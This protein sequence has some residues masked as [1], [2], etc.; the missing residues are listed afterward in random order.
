MADHDKRERDRRH[1]AA[2]REAKPWRAWYASAE[3]RRKRAEQLRRFPA[4]AVA[5]CGR[6]ASIVDHVV[7]HGGDWHRFWH[8][9]LQSLCKP[10]HDGLKQSLERGDRAPCGADGLPLEPGHPWAK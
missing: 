1:D 6:P 2:R 7:R 9:R 5:H 8:G 3:W 10:H 4:C